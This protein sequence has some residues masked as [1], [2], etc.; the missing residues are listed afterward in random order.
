MAQTSTKALTPSPALGMRELGW[1]REHSGISS[2]SSSFSAAARP[3]GCLLRREGSQIQMKRG[4]SPPEARRGLRSSAPAKER[5]RLP[6]D[7]ERD[8]SS[9]PPA[10]SRLQR[11]DPGYP[12]PASLLEADSTGAGARCSSAPPGPLLG[13]AG[14][15]VQGK[16]ITLLP[17]G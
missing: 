10:R 13:R 9:M 17:K 16:G 4:F 6:K 12:G 15:K 1:E 7:M 14:A 11:P 8:G 2:T 5:S 3:W